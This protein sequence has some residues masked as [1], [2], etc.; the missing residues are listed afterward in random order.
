[1]KSQWDRSRITFPLCS[2]TSQACIHQ[3]LFPY[4]IWQSWEW[5]PCRRNAPWKEHFGSCRRWPWRAI[6]LTIVACLFGKTWHLPFW[7]PPSERRGTFPWRCCPCW[8]MELTKFSRTKDTVWGLND[9]FEGK[10]SRLGT[11]YRNQESVAVRWWLAQFPKCSYR[12]SRPHQGW[13]LRTSPSCVKFPLSARAATPP[14]WH[15]LSP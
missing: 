8:A 14:C 10:C 12:W 11:A 9:F 3:K 13:L 15:S 6:S 7:L 1:M 2:A 5:V 4:R